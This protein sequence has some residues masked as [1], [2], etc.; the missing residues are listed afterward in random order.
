[1]AVSKEEELLCRRTP[2]PSKNVTS[3]RYLYIRVGVKGHAVA[4]AVAEAPKGVARALLHIHSLPPS[5][6]IH[7]SR[8]ST[9][10]FIGL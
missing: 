8:H 4:E 1:M 7:Y 6:F 9:I 5:F 10:P 2:D 3:Y